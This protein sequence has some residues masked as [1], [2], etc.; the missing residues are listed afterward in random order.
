MKRSLPKGTAEASAILAITCRVFYGLML[1]S[2]EVHNGAWLSAIAGAALALPTLS[3][4]RRLKRA[5]PGQSRAARLLLSG[6][7]IVDAAETIECTAVSA[8]YV[9]FSHAAAWLLALPA[10]VL[11][12]RAALSGG[13]ALGYSALL[14]PRIALPL[15]L[16]VAAFQWRYYRFPWLSPAFGYGMPGVLRAGLRSAGWISMIGQCR[17]RAGTQ[18]RRGEE[19]RVTPA[20]RGGFGGGG[21]RPHR[22]QA[23]HDALDGRI[24]RRSPL[25][26]GRAPDQRTGASLLPAADDRALV[27]R[28]AEPGVL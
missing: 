6:L 8:G 3:L 2:P 21:I 12:L 23:G 1:D 24:R 28:H 18:R 17:H 7:L 22:P 10:L 20:H 19:G 27:R 14:L 11:A 16:A 4:A 9:A 15:L 5:A 13:D 25:S 26:A